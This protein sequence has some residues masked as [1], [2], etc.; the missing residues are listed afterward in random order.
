MTDNEIIKALECLKGY[1]LK[2][3]DCLY[4]SKYAFPHCQQKVAS[5]AHALINRQKAEIERLEHKY[6]M[7]V[8]ER[9]AN[10]KGFL[11]ELN[12]WN[13]ETQKARVEAIKEVANKIEVE[14]DS[15]N[16]Y[17]REYSDSCEQRAYA[18]G[19]QDAWSIVKEMEKKYEIS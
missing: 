3:K 9:E 11:E 19:L 1:A 13:K 16:K 15:T 2:C 8:A 18:K 7:A 5:D 17:I 6:D 12:R 4:S 10:M 14:W